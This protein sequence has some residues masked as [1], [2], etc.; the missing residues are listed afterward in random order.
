MADLPP[1]VP[2]LLGDV[3][4]LFLDPSSVLAADDFVG[5][6]AGAPPLWGLF[7]GGVPVVVADTVTSFAYKQDWAIADYPVEQGGFESYDKVNT[8]FRA[9]IQF[10]A[11][12]SEANRE[13]LLDSI[14]AAADTL[15][16]YDAVTPE[17]IYPSVN[18]EGYDYRRTSR[19]GLGLMIV[20]VH[21]LE[22]REDQS[23][24][25]Q[26][27]AEPS[28]ASALPTGNIQ[29]QPYTGPNLGPLQGG[30]H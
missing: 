4:G 25:F 15:T 18:I 26:N 17:E 27:T 5:Y 30:G 11:G 14:A 1:G 2:P 19:N 3:A 13:A 8:P 21:I 28:G 12:G 29:A 20:N 16:L 7:L 22:I 9:Q 6:G 23:N 10:V 24:N